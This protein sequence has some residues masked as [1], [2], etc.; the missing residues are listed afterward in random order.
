[1][2][3][4][5]ISDELKRKSTTTIENKFIC[6]YLPELDPVAVKVYLYALYLA[7]SEQGGYNLEDFSKKLNIDEDNL[8]DYFA[9]LSEWE[10]LTVVSSSPLEIKLLDCDNLYG[11]PKK[12]RPEKFDGL[13]E[14]LQA[15]V[16]ERMISQNEFRDYLILLEEYGLERNALIMIV[17]Y[18]VNLK[19]ADIKAAYIKKVVK[20][21]CDDGDVTTDRVETRLSSYSLSTPALLKIFSIC[22]IKRNPEV[23]DGELYKKWA[24]LG[25]SDN[26]IC[27]AAKC[28]KVKSMEKLDAALE[29]LANN[30]KFDAKEIDDYKK[31]KDSLY[32]NVKI[33]AKSL[34]VYISDATPYVEKYYS[35]W[36]D[37]GY[38][39]EALKSI[40]DHCFLS[41]RNSFELMNDFIEQLYNDAYVDD[42]SV[43]KLLNELDEDNRFIKK[44]HTA[45][46]YTREIKPY[47]RNSLSRWR[48]WGFNDEMILKAAELSAGKNNPVAAI[49]Y[50]LSQWKNAAVYT[51][52]KIPAQSKA[53]Y[54]QPKKSMTDEWLET[55]NNIMTN[56]DKN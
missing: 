52:D 33:I 23:E 7:Q 22:S 25:F 3:F 30:R 38:S 55:L 5:S 10:L 51:I 15:I 41:G 36:V 21:F 16:N 20:N 8:M 48:N 40:A 14:E 27:C 32:S 47:D 1:M 9:Y 53:N 42:D 24:T 50:L 13:Y 17:N 31:S 12:L 46:G 26:A 4:I 44:I 2:G 45:C 29:E 37:Y 28:F 18:C 43:F 6:K 35:V 49:N 56:E 19:G 34:G 11:K 39:T 54:K